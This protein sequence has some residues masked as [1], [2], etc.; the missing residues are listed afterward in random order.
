MQ[1]K[2]FCIYKCKSSDD[3]IAVR[4]NIIYAFSINLLEMLSILQTSAIPEINFIR[5]ITLKS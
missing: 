5:K 4:L 3:L 2:A 1:S